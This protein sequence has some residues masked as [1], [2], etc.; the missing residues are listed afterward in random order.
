M[1]L[2]MDM[3]ELEMDM[4]MDSLHENNSKFAPEHVF[5]VKRLSSFPSTI[6]WGARCWSWKGINPLI[7]Y[8]PMLQWN[9][10]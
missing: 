4:Q 7:R 9:Y 10:I 2:E 5:F 3:V 6:F 8:Q 1:E